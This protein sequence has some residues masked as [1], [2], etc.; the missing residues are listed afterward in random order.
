[1]TSNFIS[2]LA[3]VEDSVVLGSGISVWEFTKIRSGAKIGNN[4]SIGIG[5][6]IGPGVTIGNN[7]RIQNGAQIF[8]PA[9]LEDNVFIGPHAI[10]TNHK[11][12][13]ALNDDG[14][15]MQSSDW[16]PVGV[17][18]KKGA[19]I[20]AN[21]TIIAG[22]TIGK[23]SLVAAGSTISKDVLEG[24]TFMGCAAKSRRT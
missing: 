23:N 1:M 6:Y 19:T 13:S 14:E 7:C 21:C 18:V 8:E 17:K 4:T 16:E 10:L 20:S 24:E 15:P 9:V 2:D 22:V 12:P 3:I 11:Y 5:V